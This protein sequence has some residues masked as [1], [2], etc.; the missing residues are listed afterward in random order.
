MKSLITLVFAIAGNIVFINAQKPG[1]QLDIRRYTYNVEL[2]DRNDSIK[3]LATIEFVLLQ[4]TS[5][6]SLDLISTNTAGKGMR[7]RKVVDDGTNLSYTHEKDVVQ[8][9]FASAEIA[10]KEKKIQVQY[11][12]IPA[13]GLI[14]S[15][16]KYN[17]RTFFS[18]H[19][20]NRARNW[21]VCI[22]HPADKA[23]FDFIIIAPNHYQVVSNGVMVEETNIDASRK[24]THYQETIPIPIK[25]AAIGVADFAVRYEKPIENVS[26]QSWVYPENRKEGFYDYALA[27]EVFQFFVRNLGPFPFKKLANVQ[28]KTIFGGMENA[29]AIFYAESTVTGHRTAEAL[30]AHEISHQWFGD[31]ATEADWPHV[32]LSEG[33]V[34]YLSILYM[35]NKYG[36]DTAIKMRLED[37]LQGLAFAKQKSR[38]VVDFSTNDYLQL[39]NANSYQKGGWVLHMLRRQLGD[40]TF[41]NSLR[42]YYNEFA[43]K[44]AVTDDFRRILEK[45]SGKDLKK[46]F[47]QWLYTAGHP[48]LDVEWKFDKTSKSTQVTIRQ[49]QNVPFEFPLEIQLMLPVQNTLIRT[50]EVKEKITTISM[51]STSEPKTLIA[52]PNANLFFE[53][54]VKQ[55][56]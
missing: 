34:T 7:V 15:K 18:D 30:I 31:M 47:E 22:D 53:V 8:I 10:G 52:D 46:F 21:L 33:F 37:R 3:L 43:G 1:S 44:N 14:I 17:H 45:T 40:S 12:G 51:P 16:N 25:I 50:V 39:L 42:T 49:L 2:N 23:A 11:E 20:P 41:W 13:D 35:E 6:I 32:W 4:N 26:I 28:S 55:A 5:K 36:Q 9:N 38:P 19:W 27:V 29:G 54:S 24:L 48:W 56:R